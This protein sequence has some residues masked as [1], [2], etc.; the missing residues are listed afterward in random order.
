MRNLVLVIAFAVPAVAGEYAVFSNGFQMHIDGHESRNG[1]VVLHIGAGTLV[2]PAE[3]ITQFRK[4]DYVAPAPAQAPSPAAR[5]SSSPKEMVAEAARRAVLP[6]R[7]V[8]SVAAVESAFQPGAVSSKGAVG[9]MQLMPATAAAHHA[10]PSNPQQNVDAG[11][12][13]LRELLLKYNGDVV[14]ALAA[15]NAGPGAVDRFGGLPP[16]RET[17]NYVQRV[18]NLYQKGQP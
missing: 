12:M 8:E 14:K 6:E 13:Y 4:D 2:L 1:E 3:Q 5:A 17:Q 9:I 15:Y 11:A 18:L 16:F 7:F 10:D